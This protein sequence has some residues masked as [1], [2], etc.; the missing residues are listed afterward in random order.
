MLKLG[1]KRFFK[2]NFTDLVDCFI[3]LFCINSIITRVHTECI[4]RAKNVLPYIE[5]AIRAERI[6]AKHE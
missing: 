4:R 1:K 3:F 2:G 5:T 6:G